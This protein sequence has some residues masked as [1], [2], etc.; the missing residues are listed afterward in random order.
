MV[1]I[2]AV[3]PQV[4]P[5]VHLM[6][7]QFFAYNGENFSIPLL[8]PHKLYN[9][10]YFKPN[11]N[12]TLVVTGWNSNVNSTNECLDTLLL[13]Y[14]NRKSNFVVWLS[15]YFV[16][17]FRSATEKPNFIQSNFTI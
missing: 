1:H 13:A 14:K 2:D 17:R 10:S 8:Q 12:I 15:T 16:Y 3:K 11:W 4:T 6:N 7:F 9:N 5:S